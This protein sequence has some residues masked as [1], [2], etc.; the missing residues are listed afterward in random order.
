MIK[1]DKVEVVGLEHAIRGMRAKGYRKTKNGNFEC[2]VSVRQKKISLG[3]YS[4]ENEAKEVVFKHRVQRFIDGITPLNPSDCVVFNE[5]YVIFPNGKLF[6][7]H[8]EEIK[9]GIGRCGYR[10]VS[11]NNKMV[12]VHRIV[13]L[14]F[15]KEE[16][17]KDFVNH[18]NGIKTDNRVEN[19]EWVTKSEN[20][21]H[22]YRNGLQKRVGLNTCYTQD[23]KEYIRQNCEQNYKSIARHL[24]RNEETVRKYVYKARKGILR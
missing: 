24:G 6:N 17:G 21:L 12:L 14:A 13:A 22:S 19:L 3:T 23:E 16:K 10:E 2:F 15:L 1:I 8:G 18:K 11:I 9:G 5:K 20:T 7:L 4:T